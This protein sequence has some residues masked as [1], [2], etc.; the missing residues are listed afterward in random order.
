MSIPI[1]VLLLEDSEDDATLLLRELRRSGF[2]PIWEHHEEAAGLT[3]A[4]DRHAW[5][6]ILCDYHMPAF[7]ALAALKLL[8]DLG[9]DLPVIVVSGE[10]GDEFVLSALRAGARAYIVKDDLRDLGA[11]VLREL[12]QPGCRRSQR[13]EL[14][15]R[16]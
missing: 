16:L 11:A 14:R 5:D 6:I 1:R 3:A 4:L 8:Q 12:R 13:K 7:S 10:V 15:A 2:E 9:L